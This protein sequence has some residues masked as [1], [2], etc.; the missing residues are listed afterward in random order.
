MAALQGNAQSP[1]RVFQFSLADGLV[2]GWRGVQ[3]NR[4]VFPVAG[5]ETA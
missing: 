2:I 4:W 3:E 1:D 5:F